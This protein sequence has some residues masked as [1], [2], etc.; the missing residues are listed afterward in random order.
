MSGRDD[1]P[2]AFAGGRRKA[3]AAEIPQAERVM[4]HVLRHTFTAPA[5]ARGVLLGPRAEGTAPR[6]HGP[7]RVPVILELDRGS[8][9]T[10]APHSRGALGLMAISRWASGSRR[11]SCGSGRVAAITTRLGPGR[12]M[13]ENG[14][15]APVAQDRDRHQDVH[16]ACAQR[17]RTERS[18]RRRGAAAVTVLE[19]LAAD[20]WNCSVT[21]ASWCLR[22][23]LS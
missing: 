20:S 11:R 13:C 21:R 17:C 6:L 14:R 4:P 12:K 18:S 22:E 3:V 10:C 19:G 16:L 7:E 15:P 9:T 8:T 2:A 23:G 5:T 1:P